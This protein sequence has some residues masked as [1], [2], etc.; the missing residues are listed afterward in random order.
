MRSRRT[1]TYRR[2]DEIR[3]LVHT[4]VRRVE[5]I[6]ERV[7]VSPS[8][9]RRDLMYLENEGKV[10]R[11]LGG[12]LPGIHYREQALAE[13]E[14]VEPQAKAAM[15]AVAAELIP[16]GAATVFIDA[17]SSCAQILPYLRGR[18]PLT[19]VTRGLEIALALADDPELEVIVV[20]GRVF[21]NSHSL[22][23]ALTTMVLERLS[24]DIAFIGCDSVHPSDGVGEPTAEEA[25]TKELVAHRATT[26]VVLAHA[27]KLGLHQHAWARPPHGWVLVTDEQDARVLDP[28]RVEGVRVI[29]APVVAEEATA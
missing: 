5:D 25:H 19:V 1:T 27:Q 6:A 7:G 20:G 11:T 8:T 24:V 21:Q 10:T 9:V 23:G 4:G 12:A 3:E 14:N 15:A 2:Q 17:G 16:D 28:Y 26:S 22:S 29:T 18:G 13:R